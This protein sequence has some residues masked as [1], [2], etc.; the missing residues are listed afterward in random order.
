MF[1]KSL[2]IMMLSLTV[3]AITA[4]CAKNRKAQQPESNLKQF[5]PAQP[6]DAAP[7]ASSSRQAPYS[8]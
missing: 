1:K 5:E 4:G 8:K 7:V 3:L 2:S 6:V